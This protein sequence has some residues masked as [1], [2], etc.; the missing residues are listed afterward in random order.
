MVHSRR[1]DN[2]LYALILGGYCV[3]Y[4]YIELIHI[5][6]YVIIKTWIQGI[7]HPREENRSEETE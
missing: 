2:Y 4:F 1:F 3:D 7:H 6:I 5:I